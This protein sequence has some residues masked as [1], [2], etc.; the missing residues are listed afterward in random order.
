MHVCISL[1][2]CMSMYMH[3]YNSQCEVSCLA[4]VS[5]LAGPMLG[6]AGVCMCTECKHR[7]NLILSQAFRIELSN[8]PIIR[9]YC[10]CPQGEKRAEFV[11]FVCREGKTK[12]YICHIFQ[13]ASEAMVSCV[14]Y[15]M[16]M[17]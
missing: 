5:M 3:N 13:A 1:C 14:I 10:M 6:R 2:T 12:A 8:V 9:W 15:C 7:L 11:G 17:C 4:S 16:N